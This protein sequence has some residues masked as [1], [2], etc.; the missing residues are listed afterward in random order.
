MHHFPDLHQ[1][2]LPT[3]VLEL[4]N[5]FPFGLRDRPH[6][7]SYFLPFIPARDRALKL[8]EYYYQSFAWMYV[9]EYAGYTYR[10][11]HAV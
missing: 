10:L 3:E 6:T 9:S 8:T 4:F 7:K 5:A 1:L 2:G 11:I